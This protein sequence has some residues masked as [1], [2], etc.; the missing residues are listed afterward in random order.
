MSPIPITITGSLCEFCHQFI[1]DIFSFDFTSQDAYP[2]RWHPIGSGWGPWGDAFRHHETLAALAQSAKSCELCNVLHADLSLMDES[3]HQGWLGLYPFYSSGR[4]GPNKSKGVFRA[5][6]RDSLDRMPWGSS[7]IGS[8]PLHSFKVCRRVPLNEGEQVPWLD[9]YRRLPAVNPTITPSDIANMVSH[10]QQDCRTN[11]PNCSNAP[12]DHVLP[13]RVLDLGEDPTPQIRLLET[14]DL[15]APYA[16]LSHCWGGAIPSITLTTNAASRTTSL[17]LSSL[18]QNFKD[19]IT[20]TRALG[21]RYLWIDALCIVQDSRSDWVREAGLMSAVYT[22]AAVVI[23]ALDSPASSAGFLKPDRLPLAVLGAE[24]AVQKVLPEL[25]DYLVT[26]PL[27]SRG[28]C[29]QERLLASRLLHFGKEQVFWECRSL[30]RAEDGRDFTGDSDGHVMAEFLRIRKRI[31]VAAARGERL[32]WDAWYQLL[33]EYTTRRF[34]VST[35]KLPA[36]AG[37]AGLFRNANKETGA[38]Y[39]AGLWKEDLARGLLWCAHYDHVP[40][41][42]VWGISSSDRISTLAEPPERRAPSWSWAALDGHLDFWALRVGGFV[43]EVL[44]VKMSVGE[45][46]LTEAF[47]D[48]VVTLR[49]RVARMFYHTPEEV[50]YDVGTLTFQQSDSPSDASS[51][52]SG[53][54]M[55]LDRRKSRFCW[56]M[57]I[58]QSNNEWFLLVLDKND[59][60]SYRRIGMATAKSVEV[61]LGRF[62][63][64]EVQII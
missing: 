40:G 48:G 3:L 13:T 45:N 25:N 7:K 30:F 4:I 51:A 60:G 43:V 17:P 14:H 27:V 64:H 53:C 10:W 22:G 8:I 54:V 59:D 31:G 2:A 39:V 15:K 23:S 38:T 12:A 11:H 9:T 55:D 18:P 44:D 46:E 33:Q 50:K 58:A 24:Y 63:V 16:T 37:A 57:V 42:K 41:R 52:L 19:A 28:W 26:C 62:E 56:A 5:G 34:T 20:V 1:S 61:D 36:L 6:F 49:G 35:D 32:D 21:L 29:M 47:P